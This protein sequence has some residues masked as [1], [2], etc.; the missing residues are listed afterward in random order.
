MKVFLKPHLGYWRSGVF[1]WRGDV[2]FEDPAALDRFFRGYTDWIVHQA[3]LAER[4]GVDLFCMGLEYAKLEHHDGRWRAVIAAVRE[5]YAGPVTYAA[6][7]DRLDEVT[8]WDALDAVAVQA[9]FPLVAEDTAAPTDAELRAGWGR[10]LAQLHATAARTDRPVLLAE[11]GYPRSTA[12]ASRPWESAEEPWHLQP[13][14]AAVPGDDATGAALKARC[15]AIALEALDAEPAGSPIA[16]AFLWKWFPTPRRLDTEFH[17][18]N[19]P[20]IGV[21]EQAWEGRTT[22][23]RQ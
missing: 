3:T 8:F 15:L 10:V 12:A 14:P 4:A 20:M 19:A 16:G 2:G 1:G 11:L 23:P 5:V 18:Q 6:N 21:I 13:D 7:W 22:T 17:L 9:Y